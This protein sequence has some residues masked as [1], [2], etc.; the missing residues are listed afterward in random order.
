MKLIEYKEQSNHEPI[1][2]W[3]TKKGKT[4]SPYFMTKKKA[5]KWLDRVLVEVRNKLKKDDD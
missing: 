1:Y 3:V 4:L 2:C 5:E